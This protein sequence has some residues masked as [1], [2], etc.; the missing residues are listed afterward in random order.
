MMGKLKMSTAVLIFLVSALILMAF[1]R[2]LPTEEQVTT[3]EF[4]WYYLPHKTDQPPDPMEKASYISDYDVLYLGNTEQKVIYLTFDDCPDNGNIPAI[5]D[6]LEDHHATAAFFMTE[7]F[8]R[9][10]PEIIRKIVADGCLVCN[11]T[12]HHVGVSRVSFE[13]FKA[14]LE[15]VEAAY[16]EV[17]GEEL[18]KFFR[19]PQGL[20]SE[21]TLSYAEE[22]GYTTV[23]WSFRYSDWDVNN[24]P[25]D[26]AAMSAILKETHPGEIALLHSQSSANVH[27]L[28]HVL[29]AWEEAG[30]TFG[31]L[32]DIPRV[33][34]TRTEDDSAQ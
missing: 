29:T 8:I 30:Y 12:A 2:F 15:G 27:I 17:T 34:K 23:F 11:H 7:L 16:R 1:A 24:Q 13:K 14:E 19:P 26:E 3:D 10:H 32:N 31:S 6:V 9:Q 18:P 22:M 20:F 4:M 21:K 25:T 33:V 5:L 28:D